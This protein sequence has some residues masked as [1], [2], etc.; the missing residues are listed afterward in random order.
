M[1]YGGSRLSKEAVYVASTAEKI[2]KMNLR[3]NYF[4]RLCD[5][6]VMIL[7]ARESCRHYRLLLVYLQSGFLLREM[8][9]SRLLGP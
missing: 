3:A 6:S 5:L 7:T 4:N 8:T 1:S 9:S 2:A